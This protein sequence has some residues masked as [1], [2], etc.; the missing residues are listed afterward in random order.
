M[1]LVDSKGVEFNGYES[2]PHMLVPPIN[3][4]KKAAS[5]INWLNNEIF[6]RNKLFAEK[7]IQNIMQYNESNTGNEKLPYTVLIIDEFA[8]IA[9]VSNG[10][11][12]KAL[13]NALKAGYRFGINVILATQRPSV[14]LIGSGIKTNIQTK[15][16]FA[17]S[18][19]MDSKIILDETGA[20]K[21]LGAGDLLYTNFQNRTP[22]RVQSVYVSSDEINLVCAKMREKAKEYGIDDK[23]YDEK[24][25]IINESLNDGYAPN[26]KD[27]LYFEA[28][29]LIIKQDNAS[30][31]MIQRR[32]RIGF[33]RSAHI[34][35]QLETNGVISKQNG[36]EPRRVLM[37][38]S[39]FEELC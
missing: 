8:D 5:A 15:I 7:G 32:F 36:T 31:G 2:F 29:K 1:L 20:E 10:E 3:S 26:E 11:A 6:R 18:S 13:S 37:T 35:D 33:N 9:N 21:L 12:S 30:I 17:T 39:E 4:I 14:G 38:L 22:S 16:S 25:R 28:G 27:D 34:I 23:F 19:G 24:C